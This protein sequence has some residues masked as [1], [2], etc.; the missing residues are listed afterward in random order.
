MARPVTPPSAYVACSHCRT[1]RARRDLDPLRRRRSGRRRSDRSR[2]PTSTNADQDRR[3]RQVARSRTS[4]TASDAE[5]ERHRRRQRRTAAAAARRAS[6]TTTADERQQRVVRRRSAR[7]RCRDD[8]WNSK[9]RITQT[10]Q[11][12]PND[13][14]PA[15]SDADARG[16]PRSDRSDVGGVVRGSLTRPSSHRGH[17]RSEL[18]PFDRTRALDSADDGRRR[19]SARRSGEALRRLHRGR[20][21][22]PADAV[23]ASSSRCSA[24]RA[25][26]RPRRCG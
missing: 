8:R 18:D 13:Q 14:Y 3:R 6:I 11:Y 21:H 23:R 1:G 10:P 22:Q 5:G 9:T 15:S 2:R 12:W 16:R 20:R 19:G 24:R 4:P 17:A 26:A 7:P 25:A